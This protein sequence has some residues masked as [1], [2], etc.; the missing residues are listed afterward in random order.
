MSIS[1]C[2]TDAEV[3]FRLRISYYLAVPVIDQTIP[4]YIL[5]FSIPTFKFT[6]RIIQTMNGSGI[7]LPVKSV[8]WFSGSVQWHACL[9]QY[10]SQ[11]LPA[12]IVGIWFIP[13]VN[14]KVPPSKKVTQ[15]PALFY[16]PF[17][18]SY[19]RN[20]IG[21]F[22]NFPVFKRNVTTYLPCNAAGFWM[23]CYR[24]SHYWEFKSAVFYR[25]NIHR[26]K[27]KACFRW[28]RFLI[29]QV[30]SCFNIVISSELQFSLEQAQVQPYILLYG[31]FPV[32]EWVSE[33]STC[34]S[35][36]HSIIVTSE[37]NGCQ[38]RIITGAYPVITYLAITESQ[39]A[40][41]KYI[42][43]PVHE[44]F[45]RES[46]CSG[47]RIKITPSWFGSK[48]WRGIPPVYPG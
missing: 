36:T 3:K 9:V 1:N 7:S 18:S 23:G 41:I 16:I 40:I 21:E 34:C 43:R 8:N 20:T 22:G 25:T 12:V 13:L 47:S 17:I 31:C 39:L 33:N 27:C 35:A 2:V 10:H 19:K 28:Y 5:P 26:S 42:S 37:W 11:F 29:Q 4:V 14:T 38:G 45:I 15:L 48:S 6:R 46:P 32:Y 44:F 30:F 24:R